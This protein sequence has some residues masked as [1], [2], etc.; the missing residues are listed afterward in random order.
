MIRHCEWMSAW[1]TLAAG[2]VGAAIALGGQQWGRRGEHRIQV[3]ELLL[4]QCACIIALSTD[5]RNRAW[6]ET[7]LGL[8]GRVDSWDLGS[9]R[10]ARA[11]IELL[12]KDGAVL[13]ALEGLA[14][15]GQDYGAHLRRGD[16]DEDQLAALRARDIAACRAFVKESSQVVRRRLGSV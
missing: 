1:V 7:V 6:E 8:K 10:L 15:S 2:V 9:Y 4:E 3:G 16:L 14:A 12:C 5:F 11:R 13:S